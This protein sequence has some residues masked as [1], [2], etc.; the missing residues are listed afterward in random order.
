MLPSMQELSQG[1]NKSLTVLGNAS[2][3][4][5]NAIG[6][7]VQVVSNAEIR[8]NTLSIPVK[9]FSPGIHVVK[10]MNENRVYSGKVYLGN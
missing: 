2:V 8:S 7:E 5:Y 3:I 6:Q 4:L 10:I 1:N 9:S